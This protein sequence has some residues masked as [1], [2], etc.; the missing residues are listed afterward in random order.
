MFYPDAYAIYLLNLLLAF[1]QPK[2]DPSLQEDLL[3][4][5]IEEGGTPMTSPLPSSRDDEFR[6]F[7]RRLP[8]WQ[9]WLSATRA[10]LVATGC[11]LFEMFD[12]PVYWPILVVYFFVLFALTMR[13]QIQ[14][15]IK[16]K[17]IPFDI[18]RKARYGSSGR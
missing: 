18:G 7:V 11:T 15:M 5:E 2:F 6:P 10:T 12:V 16:Y 8:E 1:L 14:H 4:D 9:F 13:R 3:A 17:Y